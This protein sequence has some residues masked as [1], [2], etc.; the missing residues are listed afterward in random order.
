MESAS[1]GLALMTRTGAVA[2][3]VILYGGITF[4]LGGAP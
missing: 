2:G 4:T 1:Q 3:L